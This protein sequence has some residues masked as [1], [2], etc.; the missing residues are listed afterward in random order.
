MLLPCSIRIEKKNW[1]KKTP[2]TIILIH[3]SL[4]VVYSEGIEHPYKPGPRTIWPLEKMLSDL[5]E[6]QTWWEPSVG[7][8]L[9]W[10]VSRS[11]L[12]NFWSEPTTLALSWT[13]QSPVS[14]KATSTACWRNLGLT[15]LGFWSIDI[16]DNVLFSHKLNDFL[17]NKNKQK[18]G[19]SVSFVVL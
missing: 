15:G 9:S 3:K 16:S 2:S 14:K 1:K 11:E 7:L 10:F 17:Y 8:G 18:G 13:Q 6:I 12:S 5:R 19:I 4:A